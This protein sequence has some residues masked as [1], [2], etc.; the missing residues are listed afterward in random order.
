MEYSESNNEIGNVF[1]KEINTDINTISNPEQ[2]R[3]KQKNEDL[4]KEIQLLKSKILKV[5]VIRM[6]KNFAFLVSKV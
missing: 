4:Q 5:I 1:Q 6:K 2:L 3:L